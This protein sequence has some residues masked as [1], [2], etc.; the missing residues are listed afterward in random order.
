MAATLDHRKSILFLIIA[1]VLWSTSGLFIKI[2]DWEPI[3]IL[4]AR[5][6]FS[7]A[8][9]L[10]YLRRFPTK[11]NRWQMLAAFG[12][13]TTQLLFISS[14]QLTTA[15]NSI[16]LQYTAPI[17]VIV[18][19]YWWLHEKPTRIDWIS[20]AIIFAGMLLFFGD[21]LNFDG[22]T[23]NILAA[24]SGVA[25]ALMMIGMRA[26]KDGNP[27]ESILLANTFTAIAGFP[28]V[29]NQTWTPIDWTILI[30]LGLIQ[31]GLSFILYS[32]AIKHVP[33]LDAV[34]I[35]TLEPI[36]NPLWVFL[37]I[38]ET[39]GPLALIGAI[40]VLIGVIVNAAANP[41]DG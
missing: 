4:S 34:L 2:L 28:F 17:Y 3:A 22:Y 32:A 15:A 10:I 31:I 8:L 41:A 30:Y 1:A 25:M 26:Q 7:G 36:F 38:G 35:G 9:F 19:A 29:W 18:L 11:F 27:A 23:G 12:Y 6:I 39:P 24:L 13:V 5:S 16:F 40:I 21:E 14:T 37:F 33:A 20:M